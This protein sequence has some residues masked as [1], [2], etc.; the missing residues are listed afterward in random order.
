MTRAINKGDALLGVAIIAA[1]GLLALSL[2]GDQFSTW[3]VPI[4]CLALA[5]FLALI[6]ILKSFFWPAHTSEAPQQAQTQEDN[7][8]SVS[9]QSG[10]PWR[11]ILSIA[12]II[13]FFPIAQVIGFPAALLLCVFLLLYLAGDS[14]GKSFLVSFI[15]TS[16]LTIVFT[17][18]VYLPLPLGAGPFRDVSLL[19]L[20]FTGSN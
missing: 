7:K 3:L 4:I 12:L 11:S 10:L 2:M 5:I 8:S 17:H 9:S 18:V 1:S 19:M 13:L 20:Y 14:L 6:M 15:A 16:L